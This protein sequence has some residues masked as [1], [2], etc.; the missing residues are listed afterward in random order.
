MYTVCSGRCEVRIVFTVEVT[1]HW[2]VTSCN[3][4]SAYQSFGKIWLR[5]VAEGSF[6]LICAEDG[7]STF[8]GNRRPHTQKTFML[9][10]QTTHTWFHIPEDHNLVAHH[11]WEPQIRQLEILISNAFVFHVELCYLVMDKL[12]V[13]AC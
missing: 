1:V 11:C 2:D 7:Y 5:I 9:I 13:Y 6:F 4:V 3:L 10:Y 8:S 12:N